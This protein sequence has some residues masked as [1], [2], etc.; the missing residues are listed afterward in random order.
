[1]KVLLVPL[2]SRGDVQPQLMLVRNW[3]VV[4]TRDP[5]FETARFTVSS[6]SAGSKSASEQS[7]LEWWTSQASRALASSPD[8]E[9]RCAGEERERLRFEPAGLGSA[10]DGA[11]G[12]AAG[13]GSEG[14]GAGFDAHGGE[15]AHGA[16][17]ELGDFGGG[18]GGCAL[19]D[20]GADQLD[21]VGSELRLAF[22]RHVLVVGGRQDEA[23]H[24]VALRAVVRH[25]AGAAVAAFEQLLVL[26]D[27][28]AAGGAVL[29][30]ALA[31]VFAEERLD[32]VGEEHDARRQGL[33][34]RGIGRA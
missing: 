3:R 33:Q 6:P 4:D 21:L 8:R 26:V 29:D 32:G 5:N 28:E 22:G 14:F 23:R 16:T 12:A 15:G 24:H 27:A 1:M 34:Q 11:S 20:P 7:S 18:A 30:V 10:G 19:I 17:G 9:E 25:D 2:G 31:A 13:L